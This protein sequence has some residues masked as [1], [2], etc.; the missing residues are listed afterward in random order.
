M[1]NNRPNS[2]VKTILLFPIHRNAVNFVFKLCAWLYTGSHSMF[3]ECIHSFAD[4]TNQII[5]AYGIHK[6]TQVHAHCAND[7]DTNYCNSTLILSN[8]LIADCRSR[9]PIRIY[10]HEVCV[11]IDFGRWNFLRWYRS[12]I[13][14]WHTWFTDASAMRR[15]LLGI[16]YTW[17]FTVV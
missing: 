1:K 10:Q 5:L 4:T 6:S 8:F 17:R 13:L 12:I 15:L 14:S 16:L 11:I 9:S 2:V 3:A 7:A